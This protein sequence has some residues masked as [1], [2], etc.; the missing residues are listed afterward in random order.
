MN[1]KDFQIYIQ[2]L[3]GAQVNMNKTLVSLLLVK[4]RNNT[5]EITGI[6]S[7]EVSIT[8]FFELIKTIENKLYVNYMYIFIINSDDNLLKSE[9]V[10]ITLNSQ[11]FCVRS[12]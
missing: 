7:M 3:Y 10:F 9:F 5:T 1:W 2:I 12:I 11:C 8:W 4:M 6:P